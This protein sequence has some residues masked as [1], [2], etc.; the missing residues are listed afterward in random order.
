MKKVTAILLGLVMVLGLTACSSGTDSETTAA[1]TTA[2]Q[3]TEEQTT[4]AAAEDAMIIFY[5]I[6]YDDAGNVTDCDWNFVERGEFN[7]TYSVIR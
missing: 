2:A 6:S 5:S 3:T 7:R 4:E 1:Q